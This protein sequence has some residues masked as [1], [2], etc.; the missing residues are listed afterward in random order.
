MLAAASCHTPQELE[1]AIELRLDF[2]V[3]GPVKDK[4][5]RSDGRASP[6]R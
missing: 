4:P 1:R 6:A 3:L 2:A 5:L